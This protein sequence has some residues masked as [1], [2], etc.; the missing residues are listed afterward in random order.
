VVEIAEC[1]HSIDRARMPTAACCR[2]ASMLDRLL[3][4]R[5]APTAY[6]FAQG[7]AWETARLFPCDRLP[8][9]HELL[10]YLDHTTEVAFEAFFGRSFFGARMVGSAREVEEFSARCLL[11]VSAQAGFFQTFRCELGCPVPGQQPAFAEIGCVNAWRSVGAVRIAK[12]HLVPSGFERVWQSVR[13]SSVGRD[14]FHPKA[15]EFAFEYPIAHWF[16]VPIS[17]P[18]ESNLISAPLLRQ[19]IGLGNS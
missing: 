18:G 12:R 17:S 8:S 11:A 7:G 3:Q 14:S 19:A 4:F 2:E 10:A 1:P 9:A 6:Q 16:G 15:L 13:E 5:S